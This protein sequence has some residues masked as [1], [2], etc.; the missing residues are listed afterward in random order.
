MHMCATAKSDMA[1]G[2]NDG[3]AENQDRKPGV[4]SRMEEAA[5]TRVLLLQELR[6]LEERVGEAVEREWAA[7]EERWGELQTEREVLEVERA[8]VQREREE[9]E[10]D[11]AEV[12]RERERRGKKERGR[13]RRRKRKEMRMMVR[14]RT[15]N[16]QLTPLYGRC[17]IAW[18]LLALTS[19]GL[20]RQQAR[21]E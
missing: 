7:I 2:T 9:V 20:H 18:A 4:R 12:E 13:G 6:A 11:R 10:A 16:M 21:Q 1:D 19:R 14:M 8:Q 5:Q 3:A 15:R 17:S